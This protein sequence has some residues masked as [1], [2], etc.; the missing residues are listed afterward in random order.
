MK[1]KSVELIG[2][3]SFAKKTRINFPTGITE[4]VGPNG[5]GKSNIIEAIRWALGEQSAKNLRSSRMTDVIF[6]GSQS[7]PALN[8]AK[9]ALDFD[10]SDHFI[11]TNYTDLQI[12]R[13]VYRDGTNNYYLNGKPCRLRDIQDLFMNTRIGN[14]SFSI[15]SQGK[16]AQIFKSKPVDRRF[17]IETVA[18]IYKYRS[19]KEIAA[20][21]LSHVDNNFTRVSDLTYELGKRRHNLGHE[22]QVAQDYLAKKHVAGHLDIDWLLVISKQVNQKC[23]VIQKHAQGTTKRFNQFQQ[24]E[25]QLQDKNNNMNQRLAQLTKHYDHTQEAILNRS[26]QLDVL[27]NQK[28]LSQQKVSF[29]RHRIE[30][31]KT[32]V[33]KIKQTI[34]ALNSKHLKLKQ[35]HRHFSQ[36]AT[37]LTKQLNDLKPKR[38]PQSTG[39][40]RDKITQFR[41][42]YIDLV[43]RSANIQSQIQNQHQ[44][45]H[46]NQVRAN[47]LK[48]QLKNGKQLIAKS[49]QQLIETN[50]T[51]IHLKQQIARETKQIET[52][53]NELSQVSQRLRVIKNSYD[54]DIRKQQSI[55]IRSHGLKRINDQ[56]S[57]LYN[58]TRNLLAHQDR[59]NGILGTVANF[60]KVPDQYIQAIETTLRSQL[61]QIIV[62]S[63]L[64]ARNIVKFMSVN[65]LGRVTLLPIN[66][67]SKRWINPSIID[68]CRQIYGFINVAANLVQMP[69]Q[70]NA[71]KLHLLGNVLVSKDI[72]S[73]VQISHAVH[74]RYR[75][76][77]LDGN[78]VNAGGS[79]T[80]GHGRYRY[81][82]LLSQKA[83]IDHYQ[84]LLKDLNSIVNREKDKGLQVSKQLSQVQQTLKA[85]QAHLN[86]DQQRYAVQ[87]NVE[88]RLSDELRN[89]QTILDQRKQIIDNPDGTDDSIQKFKRT[90]NQ[91]KASLKV[92][93]QKLIDVQKKVDKQSSVAN[94]YDQKYQRQHESLIKIQSHAEQLSHDLK[95]NS[96]QLSE[97]KHNLA[98]A[99]KDISQFTQDIKHQSQQ[100]KSNG[101]LMAL[102]K[103]IDKL[104]NQKTHYH[105]LIIKDKNSLYKV[106]SRLSSLQNQLLDLRSRLNQYRLTSQE[107]E[108]KAHE[109]NGVLYRKYQIDVTKDNVAKPTMTLNQISSKLFRA[110]KALQEIGPVNVNAIK[111]FQKIDRRYQFFTKQIN[112]LVTA[113]HQLM[114]TM[115]QMDSKIKVRFKDTFDKINAAF[116]VTYSQI[117]KG[118][119]AKLELIDPKHLLTTGVNIMAQP[120]GK[121]YRN[122]ELLSGGERALT[123]IALLFAILKIK[124]AP[125]CILDEAESAL[126]AV[127]IDR[128]GDYMQKLKSKTQFIVITHRKTTMLYADNLYGVTMQN[129][130]VSKIISVNL[131]KAK[132]EG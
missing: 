45:Y 73:A 112:D 98:Q 121:R 22:K 87:K 24:L 41:N 120:P 19:Q 51:L 16:V 101:N 114:T 65:H 88:E 77:T 106:K 43:K 66:E 89:Y 59:F 127:N 35:S 126:D 44:N 82:G 64:T 95:A 76:V 93:H 10:N 100:V 47:H 130:G 28:S 29:W 104:N 20:N 119:R 109:V 36:K 48:A 58:G 62:D 94:E 37:A 50:K 25:S 23:K 14:G 33:R 129:S 81:H 86:K 110:Q 57:N 11:D 12:A 4:I 123:A 85:K 1:L 111:Q 132:T 96:V 78:V 8:R 84:K 80:G 91:I 75:V 128:F 61:Q 3:K 21:K 124:P 18:G 54:H 6:S 103:Q 26:R 107:A 125:F 27:S 113:K 2:F 105:E 34:D 52:L 131:R 102:S 68:Q 13:T 74:R 92:N 56:H 9:V 40:L 108:K 55:R 71:V 116:K 15:I 115:N 17:I 46:E 53:Q 38:M 122:M 32:D 67:I 42:Q 39:H 79:V 69:D 70:F 5:S 118:G 7:Y 31:S 90:Q 30:H 72:S 83:K 49:R 117:F 97:A 60:I 99:K 63:T